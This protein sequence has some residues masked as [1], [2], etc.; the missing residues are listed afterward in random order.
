MAARVKFFGAFEVVVDG[1]PVQFST[2]PTESLFAFLTARHGKSIPRNAVA[3]AVWPEV[4]SEKATN[5]LRTALVH[6]KQ[7]L[8]PWTPIEA[9]RQNVSVSLKDGDSDLLQAERLYRRSRIAQN[10]DEERETLQ[11]L[12]TIVGEDLLADWREPWVEEPRLHWRELRIEAALRLAS[13]GIGLEEYE[14][15]ETESLRALSVDDFNEEAWAIYLRTMME[16][17]HQSSAVERFGVVRKRRLV[18][19]GFDFSGEL[20]QLAKRVSTGTPKPEGESNRFTGAAREAIANALERSNPELLLPVLA[21]EAFKKESLRNPGEAWKLLADVIDRTDGTDPSRIQAMKLAIWL[22]SMVDQY[23]VACDYA[24][25]IIENMPED[26]KDHRYALNMLG[27]MNFEL[28]HWDDAWLH[29][30]RFRELA[31]KYERPIEISIARAQIASLNWHQG[32]LDQALDE[33]RVL[34]ELFERDQSSG[35]I[36]NLCAL[37]GNIGMVLT[38]QR[39]WEEAQRELSTCYSIAVSNGHDYL[40]ANT[41]APLGVCMIMTGQK[42]EGRKLAA[43]GLAHTYRSRYRRMHEIS[44]DYAAAALAAT[45]YRRQGLA[46]LDAYTTFRAES[47]HVRSVAEDQLATWIENEFGG[48]PASLENSGLR[49]SDVVANSCDILESN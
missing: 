35:G 3:E 43:M 31:E 12:L 24:E 4:E 41:M 2:R 34:V 10:V 7:A 11:K 40:R 19:L 23:G 21:S 29:L 38:I 20:L 33:Y 36:A 45:G 1:E 49:P 18:E 30:L 13:I 48:A 28:R 44:A 26:S 47:H 14:L 39:K 17:G 9:D 32:K 5:R 27:F 37:R 22:T 16:L 15:A 42:A 6:I 46:V 25:W 8:A